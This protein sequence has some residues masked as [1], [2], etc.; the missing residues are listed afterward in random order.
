M[1]TVADALQQAFKTAIHILRHTPPCSSVLICTDQNFD[2]PSLSCVAKMKP[3]SHMQTQRTTA[4]KGNIG[5]AAHRAL[6]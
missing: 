6:G 5:V 3:P 2:T 4:K 1:A